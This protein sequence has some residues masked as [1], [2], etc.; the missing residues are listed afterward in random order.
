MHTND[1][2]R[3]F[4]IASGSAAVAAGIAPVLGGGAAAFA[5]HRFGQI[6]NITAGVLNVGYVELGPSHGEPAFAPSSTPAVPGREYPRTP[7]AN[8]ASP[9]KAPAAVADA[10]T[11]VRYP[12]LNDAEIP[13]S[14][15][16]I[17]V[18]RTAAAARSDRHP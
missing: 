18:N 8:T 14:A 17:M 9:G 16:R 2:R 13:A 15:A 5:G 7:P 11:A 6:R 4:L 12:R 1:S 3:R 10:K